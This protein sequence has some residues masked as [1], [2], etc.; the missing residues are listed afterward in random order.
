MFYFK[1]AAGA[2]ALIVM[3]TASVIGCSGA[4]N[5]KVEQMESPSRQQMEASPAVTTAAKTFTDAMGKEAVLPENLDHVAAIAFVG[6]LLALGV[7]PAYTTEYNLNTFGE[8]LSGTESI[9]DR[10]VN[11]EKLT[12][13]APELIVTDDTDD[14]KEVEQLSKIAPAIS[15]AFWTPDPFEHMNKLAELLGKEA[16]AQ[17]WKERYDAKVQDAKSK[18]GAAVKEGDTA[19][20]LIV[21][22]KDMGVSGI[23]NGGYTLYKQLGLAWPEN[24]QPLMDENENFGYESL[25]L[26]ALPSF[27]ADYIFIEMDDTSEATKEMYNDVVNSEIWQSFDAAKE[28][29]VYTVSNKWG[30]GDATS[31]EA[32]LDEIAAQLV[33]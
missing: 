23:R 27:A 31:L 28:G 25:T 8:L 18:L 20:L 22:G 15:Y 7:K 19:L 14:K 1:N 30:L 21:S 29:H 12:A 16:E 33:K 26:E 17:A 9:G 4:N 11:L 32:Q 13:L 5:S 3:L 6:D 10:P 2:G 24:M